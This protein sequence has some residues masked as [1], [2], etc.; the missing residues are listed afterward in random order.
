MSIL[1]V[2]FNTFERNLC[3]SH[4]PG[5]S[6]NKADFLEEDKHVRNKSR[7]VIRALGGGGHRGSS[8]ESL[9][10][11]IREDLSRSSPDGQSIEGH[12]CIKNSIAKSR[13]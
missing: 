7:Y 11:N 3:A 6:G 13:K 1:F 5:L 12:L 8:W 10:G 9:P 4:Y 2:Q